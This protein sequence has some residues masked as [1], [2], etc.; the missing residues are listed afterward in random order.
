MRADNYMTTH[1]RKRRRRAPVEGN[2][3]VVVDLPVRGVAVSRIAVKLPLCEHV[4]LFDVGK[5]VDH[6]TGTIM[7]EA[8]PSAG[9]GAERRLI[10]SASG[11]ETLQR[12]MMGVE[13]DAKLLE[14]VL[15]LRAVAG[16][17]HL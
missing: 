2:I 13:S 8:Q 7:H 17:A 11:R 12:V 5:N 15:A 9:D 4:L 16:L 6:P 10:D 3:D 1:R 14:V